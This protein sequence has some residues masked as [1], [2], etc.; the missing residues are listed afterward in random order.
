MAHRHMLSPLV[1]AKAE[2]SP[3]TS[4][5]LE[6]Q[7]DVAEHRIEPGGQTPVLSVH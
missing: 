5:R 2:A 6:M 1:V 3:L 4:L 7:H